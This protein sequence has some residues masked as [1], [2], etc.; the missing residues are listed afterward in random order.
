MNIL[1]VESCLNVQVPE[2]TQALY[3]EKLLFMTTYSLHHPDSPQQSALITKQRYPAAPHTIA[4]TLNQPTHPH[5][6]RYVELGQKPRFQRS[7]CFYPEN[8]AFHD[9]TL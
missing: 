3:P 2:V 9:S 4:T 7:R 6:T 1:D 8:V 5:Q